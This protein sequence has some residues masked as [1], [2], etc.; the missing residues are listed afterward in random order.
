MIKD[1]ERHPVPSWIKLIQQ[2]LVELEG[3]VDTKQ[4]ISFEEFQKWA[5]AL[6]I[7][8]GWVEE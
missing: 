4:S 6:G 5:R 1:N 2:V 8:K 7:R 3:E